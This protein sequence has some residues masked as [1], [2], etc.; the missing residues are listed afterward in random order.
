M[1]TKAGQVVSVQLLEETATR[2]SQAG[3][4]SELAILLDQIQKSGEADRPEWK[5]WQAEA[6]LRLGNPHQSVAIANELLAAPEVPLRFKVKA[7]LISSSA[8]RLRG[9]LEA[10]VGD[11]RTALAILEKEPLPA[12]LRI[13]GHRQ[14]GATLLAMGDLDQ[15][16]REFEKGLQLCARSSDLTQMAVLED[17]LAIALAQ[18][19]QLAGALVYFERA[20]AAY[21]KLD[22]LTEQARALNNI[23]RLYYDLGQYDVSLEVLHEGLVVVRASGSKRVEGSILVNTGDTLQRMTRYADALPAYDQAL[24]IAEQVLEPRLS[25]QA[26]IG[27]GSTYCRLQNSRKARVFLRKAVYE[28]EKQGVEY[29][30]CSALLHLGILNINEG[31]HKEA[32]DFLTRAVTKLEEIGARRE[33]LNG[34]LHLAFL[35]LKTKRW[36]HLR[37]CL[38][39]VER[40]VRDLDMKEQLALEAKEVPGVIEYAASKRLYGPLF[41]EIL[42]QLQRPPAFDGAATLLGQWEDSVPSSLPLA[43]VHGLGDSYVLLD[44]RRVTEAEWRSQKAKELFLYLLCHRRGATRE[45][46]LDVLWPDMATALTRNALY[47]NVYRV[48]KALYED[49]IVQDEGRYKLNPQASFWFDLEEFQSMMDRADKLPLGSRERVECL[50]EAVGLYRGSFLEDCYSGWSDTIRFQA[51]ASYVKSLARLAS[52]YAT[53]GEHDRATKLLEELLAVD[54]ANP[55]AHEQMIRI[56]VIKGERGAAYHHYN[57]YQA[58]LTEQTGEA[59]VKSFQQ[60]CKEVDV[61][62]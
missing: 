25:C 30:R 55:E 36:A 27:V 44:Q 9:F 24:A 11:A 16:V 13:E 61:G 21:K 3:R 5:I 7:Y 54:E 8:A 51:E 10:A 46:L 6:A 28:A 35:C 32:L 22:N 41:K 2:L 47:N 26:N 1:D 34:Y 15:S 62:S 48:R 20:K 4:W 33:L 38:E 56:L 14:L 53:Q 58:V 45:Q 40:I 57:Q 52:F 50:E 18:L 31:S 39:F 12:E 43:E 42:G 60:M 29:E 37:R 19:G 49:V 23:G 17:N 59:P